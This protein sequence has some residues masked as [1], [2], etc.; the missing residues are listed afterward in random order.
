[1]ES[2]SEGVDPLVL[3]PPRWSASCT[4]GILLSLVE[5]LYEES[6]VRLEKFSTFLPLK[7]DTDML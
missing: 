5:C 3:L 7:E 1:M 4:S 6:D 2:G